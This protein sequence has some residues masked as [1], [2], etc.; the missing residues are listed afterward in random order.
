MESGRRRWSAISRHIIISIF[1]EIVVVGCLA[2]WWGGL[3]VWCS[4][5][6]A[7]VVILLFRIVIALLSF[8]LAWWFGSPPGEAH[9]LSVLQYLCM[10]LRESLAFIKLFFFFHPLEP[11]LN[12]H[13]APLPADCRPQTVLLFV[14]GFFSNAG[15]W[16]PFKRY[17]FGQ[18]LR[19]MYTIN[20][21]PEFVSIDTYVD[22]LAVRVKQ[23]C[24]TYDQRK[25]ILVGHSMGGL[26]CRAYVG[27]YGS[28][29]VQQVITLGS[30]HHGTLLAY[31]LYGPNLT[32]MRPHSAWLNRLNAQTCDVPIST[33]YSVHDN[34]IMPQNSARLEGAKAFVLAGIGH[35]SMA[36]SR[37]VMTSV[38]EDVRSNDQKT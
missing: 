30:P 2:F 26:V 3:N 37:E 17:F 22:Q 12:E 1:L 9:S 28:D 13:E 29:S 20:L 6:L 8:V 5:L 15:F 18:G 27:R 36:F 7:L 16:V 31:L 35:L 11:L 24:T 21:D 32:Q 25:L 33:H 34:I 19:A 4:L 10:V 14:H 38:L 23:I